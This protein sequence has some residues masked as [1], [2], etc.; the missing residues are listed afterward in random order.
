MRRSSGMEIVR[1]QPR[2]GHATTTPANPRFEGT[3]SHG[4]DKEFRAHKALFR[5]ASG[6]SNASTTWVAFRQAAPL[7]SLVLPRSS[8]PRVVRVASSPSGHSCAT[9]STNEDRHSRISVTR[10]MTRACTQTSCN[11]GEVAGGHHTMDVKGLLN[12]FTEQ[13]YG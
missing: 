10:A 9:F 5:A 11:D 13:T 2:K 12:P 8:V 3:R 6:A 4:V 7:P 1:E